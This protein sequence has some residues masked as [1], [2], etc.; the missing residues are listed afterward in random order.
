MSLSAQLAAVDCEFHFLAQC[1]V[2][3]AARNNLFTRLNELDPHFTPLS[4][5]DKFKTMLCPTSAISVKLVHRFIKNMLSER[6]K[7][8]RAMQT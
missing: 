8:D 3:D 7:F 1:P 6:E 2:F 4:L 5:T